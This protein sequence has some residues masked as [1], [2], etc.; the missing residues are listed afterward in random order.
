VAF[1][2]DLNVVDY[3]DVR[4]V[5]SL[6]FFSVSSKMNKL[7]KNRVESALSRSDYGKIPGVWVYP[8]HGKPRSRNQGRAVK[9]HL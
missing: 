3:S 6:L 5:F 8:F 7:D 9:G 2:V 4:R 1:T